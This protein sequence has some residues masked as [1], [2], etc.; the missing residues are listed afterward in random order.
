[1]NPRNS[2]RA[3]ARILAEL[4]FGLVKLQIFSH[5]EINKAS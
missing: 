2:S 5:D 3:L 4:K 1:M